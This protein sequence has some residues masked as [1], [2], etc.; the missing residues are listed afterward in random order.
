[1]RVV[2][3]LTASAPRLVA[4]HDTHLNSARYRHDAR[5]HLHVRGRRRALR[6]SR[7]GGNAF[8]LEVTQKQAGQSDY[9]T[10]WAAAHR[11]WGKGVPKGA[12]E[13]LALSDGGESRVDAL[14]LV[15]DKAYVAEIEVGTPPQKV[16]V[17]LDTG[18]SDVWVQSTDTKYR[19][20]KQGPHAP[21]YNPKHSNTSRA[22]E[23]AMWNIE[24]ALR[25]E[26]GFSGIMGLAKLLDNNIQ[27]PQPSFLSVLQKQLKAPVFTVDV[28][29]NATSRF[30]FG[31]VDQ[32][33]ASDNITWLDTDPTS[34]MWS[35]EFELTAWTGNSVWLYHKFQA[36][37]DT[38]TSLM[39][40]PELLASMYWEKVPGVDSSLGS[41]RFPCNVTD[42]LPDLL[43]KLPA[44][45]TDNDL[46]WGGMQGSGQLNGVIIMGDVMLK[47]LFV[48]FDVEKGRVGFANKFLH[49]VK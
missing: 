42:S 38:G 24:Y 40:L 49:D 29:K 30:D 36:I 13:M 31:R 5:R 10:A 37:I 18:S 8:T 17:L 44:L 26:T 22:I 33:L 45:T 1:M 43:L 4:T 15:H 2:S 9:L 46:C 3:P 32:T 48:A 23:D 39:F 28:R 47:A 12:A 21:R 35:V 41:Y 6:L 34:P 7:R 27:P 20:N 14:P 16:K 11:K 19:I 25:G